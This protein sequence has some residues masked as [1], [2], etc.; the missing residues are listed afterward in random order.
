M[1]ITIYIH[2]KL[3]LNLGYCHI[4]RIYI[5][6]LLIRQMSLCE[7]THEMVYEKAYEMTDD[8]DLVGKENEL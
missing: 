8:M 1:Y 2:I 4:P 5:I 7:M 6:S 3:V